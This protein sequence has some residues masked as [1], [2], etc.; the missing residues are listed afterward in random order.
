MSFHK[1]IKD[2]EIVWVNKVQ[3]SRAKQ[4]L[5]VKI[6]KTSGKNKNKNKN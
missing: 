6:N 1:N 5:E 4:I 3:F 2:V